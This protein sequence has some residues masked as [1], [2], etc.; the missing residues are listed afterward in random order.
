MRYALILAFLAITTLA[1]KKEEFNKSTYRVK[2][3]TP[4]TFTNV[5]IKVGTTENDYGRINSQE[6]STYKKF[7][8]KDYP[9]IKISSEGKDYEFKILPFE[10]PP[11]GTKVSK[12]AAAPLTFVV[13]VNSTTNGLDYHFEE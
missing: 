2:N 1:C 8:S 5:Y 10:A 4:Y 11:S 3:N 9:Y 6:T 13:D 12:R 7:G